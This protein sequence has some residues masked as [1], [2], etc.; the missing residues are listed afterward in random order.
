M[1]TNAQIKANGLANFKKNRWACIVVSIILGIC[2]GGSAGGTANSAN[3]EQIR[4][5]FANLSPEII[6][7]ILGVV[8]V[9]FLIAVVID[10][11]LFNVLQVGCQKFCIVNR[12][13]DNAQISEVTY[14]F[15]SN[16]MNIVKVMFLKDLYLCLWS[17]LCFI[18]GIIKSYSYR[19]VPYILADNPDMTASEAITLSR[20]MMNGQK[21][22]AFIY[23]LSF[24]GWYILAIITCGIVGV[25][26]SFPYKMCSDAELYT[27][28]KE[29]FNPQ[30][31]NV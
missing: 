6:A 19:L 22:N 11:L 24:I 26:Y 13:Q 9:A 31:E 28:I 2:A 27:A 20:T 18:P 7:V 10:I 21:M 23:D 3:N 29:T 16:W 8:G 1:W 17:L 5:Q 14:G 25:F 4:D 15:K 30:P 12:T